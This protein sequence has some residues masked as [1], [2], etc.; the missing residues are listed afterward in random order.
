MTATTEGTN[1]PPVVPPVVPPTEGRLYAG[2]YK[3]AEE[4]EEAIKAKDSEAHKLFESNKQLK[5]QMEQANQ[6]P[7]HYDVPAEAE[8][9][10][11]DV[12]AI[13]KMAKAASLSQ[14]K[15]S[16]LVSERINERKDYDK[17]YD[18]AKKEVGDEN[19][20]ILTDYVSKNYPE[21]VRK[22]MMDSFVL[23]PTARAEA[24]A[25][26]NKTLDTRTPGMNNGNPGGTPPK[27]DSEKDCLDAAKKY[28]QR[29]GDKK[30]REDLIDAARVAGEKKY[31]KR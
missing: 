23:N 2:K 6:A 27:T 7:E 20:T 8:H 14:E 5:A 25:H 17:R 11:D 18:E 21:P 10:K 1:T 12:E 22:Q 16:K 29:P 15:F 13:V 26:R 3:T 24:L 4:M 30:A 28:F 31:Q 9:I 19:L